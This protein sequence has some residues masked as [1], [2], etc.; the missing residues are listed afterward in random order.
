MSAAR[1]DVLRAGPAMSVQDLGFA[2]LEG[3]GL[4]RGGA[5]DR[6]AL[7]EAAALLGRDGVVA[8]IEMAGLGGTFTVT[9]PTRFALTG[10]KMRAS[11]DGAGLTWNATHLLH[12][13]E[14]LEIGAA[15]SGNFGYLT[16]A[17]GV[18]TPPVLGSRSCH[19][20]AGIGQ[21][22]GSGA[23]LKLGVDPEPDAPRMGIKA[24]DRFGGGTLR[25]M[26]G[27]QTGLFDEKT[28]NR[29][30][31]THYRRAQRAN[32]Q[33]VGLDYTGA[34]FVAR[35][36]GN[37][38]S[39]FIQP[40]DI[41]MTGTGDPMVLN[42]EC[43]TIGGYP[44]LGTVLP[45]DLARVAQAGPGDALRLQWLDIEAADR[46]WQSDAT[47]LAS[48]RRKVHPF[49][50]DPHMIHDLLSYQLV[51][52]VIRGDEFDEGFDEDPQ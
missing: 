44:R 40:G 27:P 4:S 38:A 47:R 22:L 21:V 8:G 13:G 20:A 19:M 49:L 23:S 28:L 46:M 45:D 9:A 2:G 18:E 36:A 16:P 14:R 5:A 39:D 6:L 52:G 42:C 33:G 29:A 26:A 51:G 3:Q 7:F 30:L 34:P 50:R 17:G 31:E 24:E 25:I 37:L 32:R 35:G 11:I 12:P 43:Q 48:L 41:Q 10:A 1:L 15:L